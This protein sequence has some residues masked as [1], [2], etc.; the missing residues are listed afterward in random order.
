MKKNDKRE[1]ALTMEQEAESKVNK[2]TMNKIL[3]W[4]F[5]L[6]SRK[7]KKKV[8]G[9]IKGVSQAEKKQYVKEIVATILVAIQQFDARTLSYNKSY[10]DGVFTEVLNSHKNINLKYKEWTEF[11]KNSFNE[12]E[13]RRIMTELFNEF[14]YI[15]T[16]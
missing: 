7:L 1:K 3:N 11:M 6:T 12:D 5:K 10:F 14:E 9:K 8:N 16:H 2:D 15:R 13:A 4:Y